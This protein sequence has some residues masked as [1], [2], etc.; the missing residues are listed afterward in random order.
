MSCETIAELEELLERA[1]H[2]HLVGIAYVTLGASGKAEGAF[3]GDLGDLGPVLGELQ[4]LN[5][6]LIGEALSRDDAGDVMDAIEQ[7]GR[8]G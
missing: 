2:G 1:R 6:T 5:A 7:E 4:I 8:P 3:V